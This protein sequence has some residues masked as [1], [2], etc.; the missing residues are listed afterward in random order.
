MVDDVEG[1]KGVIV[2]VQLGDGSKIV[3]LG[4]N[5]VIFDV[6]DVQR[7]SKDV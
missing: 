7:R 3:D 5:R 2:V 1:G 4:R 6:L